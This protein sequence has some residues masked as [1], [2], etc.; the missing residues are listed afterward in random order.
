MNSRAQ[1]RGWVTLC[2][3][4][5]VSV[6]L[7]L[8]LS[9][10]CIGWGFASPAAQAKAPTNQTQIPVEIDLGSMENSLHF[11]PDTLHFK[12]GRLYRL[13]L[14]NPSPVKH[15][16]TAKDFA[17]SVWTRKVDVAGVEI[18]GAIH[19][20]ELKPDATADW[21]FIPQKPGDYALKCVVQGHEA[22][23]MVG[24]LV[25]DE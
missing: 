20:L 17:D 15:Y 9:Y 2:Q 1:T 6:L 5:L 19:E 7:S 24:T 21:V 14:H 23:G 11:F 12:A 3:Q 4:W 22:V 10:L 8:S 16:F 25:V 13:T 18:K